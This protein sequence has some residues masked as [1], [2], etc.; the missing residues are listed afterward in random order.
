MMNLIIYSLRL[1]LLRHLIKDDEK[2]G[3]RD[4]RNAYTIMTEESRWAA[5]AA[6][7]RKQ[8]GS[9]RII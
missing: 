4:I 8:S 1:I 2:G 3:T 5:P 9:S 7:V 6:D